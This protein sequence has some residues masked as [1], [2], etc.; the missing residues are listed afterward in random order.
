MG[1]FTAPVP[2]LER[3]YLKHTSTAGTK[4]SPQEKPVIIL[5]AIMR[6]V[7]PG[8]ISKKLGIPSPMVK[9]MS[10]DLISENSID[11]HGTG[12]VTNY[13]VKKK[14]LVVLYIACGG[15]STEKKDLR[16]KRSG[17]T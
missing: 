14:H 9:R 11:K 3:L 16:N 2:R 6:D 13:V 1:P 10:P 4:S 15:Q 17:S 8:D 7:K 5:L 12:P